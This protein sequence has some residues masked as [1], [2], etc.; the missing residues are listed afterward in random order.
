MSVDTPYIPVVTI[1]GETSVAI[2][3]FDTLTATVA[4]GDAH[5]SYQWVVNNLPVAG[6]TT[7]TF[8]SNNFTY[9]REDSVTCVV[10]T[11]GACGT[12]SFGWVYISMHPEGVGTLSAGE[13]FTVVPNPNRGS[14]VL[15]G[16]MGGSDEEI[17]VEVTDMLGQVVYRQ[18]VKAS[19]GKVN[20][21]I[22]LGNIA[23]GMYLLNLRTAG[24][25][26]VFHIVVE[27]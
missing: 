12:T 15:K 21:R 24:G 17:A 5:V 25:S 9:P 7:N 8:I 16:T 6:A 2:G 13:D 19:G 4:S 20:E 26:R 23:N 10:T 11:D 1:S 14:F 18:Q 27:Q 22:Q 3:T